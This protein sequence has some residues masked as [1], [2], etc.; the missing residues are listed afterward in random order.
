MPWNLTRSKEL[1]PWPLTRI[2]RLLKPRVSHERSYQRHDH[3]IPRGRVLVGDVLYVRVCGATYARGRWAVAELYLSESRGILGRIL[4]PK[5]CL[6]CPRRSLGRRCTWY[7]S[8]GLRLIPPFIPIRSHEILLP[9]ERVSVFPFSW[10]IRE[11]ALP[12]MSVTQAESTS[13]FSKFPL[14]PHA[15]HI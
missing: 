2:P 6:A 10:V 7:A 15:R 11:A 13:K 8:H 4:V 14:L 3:P 5:V 9:L 1:S 12:E